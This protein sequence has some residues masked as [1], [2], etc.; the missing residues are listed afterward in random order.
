[1][2][3][4]GLVYSYVSVFHYRGIKLVKVSKD[5]E[6]RHSSSVFF[7]CFPPPKA[8]P[9]FV[10]ELGEAVA[11][12]P[13]PPYSYDPNGSDLPRGQRETPPCLIISFI[14]VLFLNSSSFFFFFS[15]CKVLQYYYN[16][17][18]QVSGVFAFYLHIVT[19]RDFIAYIMSLTINEAGF[20]CYA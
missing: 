2:F 3:W 14:F 15:D 11:M 5:D 19:S 12:A 1:M 4:A 9:W 20:I 16:L 7:P 10:N 13:P 6:L 8:V 18:V 17:G